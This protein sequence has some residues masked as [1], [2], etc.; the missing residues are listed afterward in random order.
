[1]TE[2][3]HKTLPDNIWNGPFSSWNEAV[4][5][6]NT[7]M[8][9]KGAFD[10]DRWLNRVTQQLLDYRREFQQYGIAQ[11]PRPCN[12]PFVCAL[13][14]ASKII[15][16]GGSSGWCW[17]YLQNSLPINLINSYTVVELESIVKHMQSSRL[18]SDVVNYQ[19]IDDP[20]ASCDLLYSN[21]VLQYFESNKQ[22]LSLIDLASPS[23]I[24]LEDTLAKGENDYFTTQS[25]YNTAIP[26]RFIGL[27]KLINDLSLKG[28]QELTRCPYVSPV[29][30]VIKPLLMDNFPKELQVRY[31]VSI[32]L[33][34]V[35]SDENDKV[36]T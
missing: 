35:K 31:S 19:T 4:N 11:P 15:D 18:H 32:L 12:L 22:L 5:N 1:M 20:L 36:F 23:F 3:N 28:Y 6:A 16:F 24:F 7:E 21:S 8:V 27:E 17:D 10:S 26:H 14:S 29:L 13:T 33:K 34:K 9:A 30:G 2:Q 25:Y